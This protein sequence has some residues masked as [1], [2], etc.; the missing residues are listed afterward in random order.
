MTNCFRSMPFRIALVVLFAA[1]LF[2]PLEAKC[3]DE[4][5]IGLIPEENIF[6]QMDRHRPLAAYVTE[7]LGV[8]VKLTIL[9]RYGDVIDR[10]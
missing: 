8:K 6:S 7:K 9:S 10:F 5:L 4:I 3:E 1:L 2:A